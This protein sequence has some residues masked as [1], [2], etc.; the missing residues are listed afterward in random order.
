MRTNSP[1]PAAGAAHGWNGMRTCEPGSSPVSNKAG[2]QIRLQGVWP[3]SRARRSSPTRPST[4]SSTPSWRGRK[5]TPGA[6]ICPEASRNAAGV[7][8]KAAARLPSSISAVP[9]SNV[10]D[11]ADRRT[12]GHWEADLMLFR[13][14]GQA[15]LTLHERHSRLLIA[16]RPPGKASNPIASAMTQVLGAFPPQWRRTVTFDNGDGVRP[17]SPAPC[18]GRRDLLL[19]HSLA[20]AEGRSGERHRTYAPHSAA[21]DRPRGVV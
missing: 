6:A 10:P 17:P 18:L 11:A 21:E 8:T 14:Y 20:L 5:T 7:D 2:L 13:T 19:R 12:P 15:V 4:G 9:W 3:W 16:L 1:E